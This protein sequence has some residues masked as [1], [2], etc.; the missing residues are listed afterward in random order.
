[1]KATTKK[2]FWK[3]AV[4]KDH[5]GY[6]YIFP[7][8]FILAVFVIVPLF[9]AFYLSLT[10]LDIFFSNFKFIGFD[11]FINSFND[12]RVRNAFK[13]TI[14]YVGLNVPL[15][16]ALAL[17]IAFLVYK[18]HKVNKIFR[19]IYYIP[20]L[21]SF[22]AVGILFQLLFDQTVGYYSYVIS[23][24]TGKV[25]G[26]FSSAKLALPA[27]IFISIWR[28]FGRSMII[29]V[30]GILD[31]PK[32]YFEAS[33]IDGA[34][35]TQQFFHIML[36]NLLPTISFTLLTTIIS[37][38][39]VFDVVFVTTGGGP[40]YKTE[41]LVQYIYLRGFSDPFDLGYASAV[42]VE[43]FLV[44]AIITIFLLSILSLSIYFLFYYI[45]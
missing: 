32:T 13:N 40:L 17:A 29:Y 20:V 31:I 25:I 11:N 21:C 18:P 7:A 26:I 22:T 37:S 44:I 9:T 4:D 24:F 45:F 1:M 23:L 19:T 12:D 14:I 15:Q 38:F 16:L 28:N 41:T 36:P 42:A 8:L 6:I 5:V 34:S 3:T 35:R 2:G 33:A 39:Q 43:L 10:N 30:A 27:I